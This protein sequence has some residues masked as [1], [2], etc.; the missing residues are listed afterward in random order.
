MEGG[1]DLKALEVSSKAVVQTLLTEPTIKGI[2][3]IL[4]TPYDKMKGKA[5]EAPKKEWVKTVENLS[6]KLVKYWPVL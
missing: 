6:H 3:N 4:Q 1:Y 5:L 2:N